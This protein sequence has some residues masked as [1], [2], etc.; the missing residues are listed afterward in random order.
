MESTKVYL[1]AFND[2]RKA[3]SEGSKYAEL[4]LI[5]YGLGLIILVLHILCIVFEVP[6]LNETIN[7]HIRKVPDN[8]DEEW[9]M[10]EKRKDEED[11]KNKKDYTISIIAISSIMIFLILVGAVLAKFFHSDTSV[12]LYGVF[13]GIGVAMLIVNFALLVHKGKLYPN[14]KKGG[15]DFI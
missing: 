8:G 3:I 4:G 5:S 1:K 6:K 10:E 11:T 14:P 9:K 15:F 2:K 7:T 12:I 13:V